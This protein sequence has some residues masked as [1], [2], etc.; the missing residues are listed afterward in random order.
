V[1]TNATLQLAAARGDAITF[2]KKII[3]QRESVD[4]QS[5]EVCAVSVSF[6]FSLSLCVSL[7]CAIVSSHRVYS[8]ELGNA[9]TLSYP[10]SLDCLIMIFG[11]LLSFIGAMQYVRSPAVLVGWSG[12]SDR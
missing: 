3:A 8:L 12:V 7:R 6:S 1:I 9:R 2:I 11:V 5:L 4:S 10:F